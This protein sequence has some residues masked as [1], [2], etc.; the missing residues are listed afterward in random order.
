[1]ILIFSNRQEPTTDFVVD[2]LLYRE[3]DFFRINSEDILESKELIIDLDADCWVID[4]REISLNDVNAV[5]YRRWNSYGEKFNL[6]TIFKNQVVNEI[7]SELDGLSQFIFLRLR[8]TSKFL[9]DPQALKQH[10]KLYSLH[11][12]QQSGLN[13]P[14]TK[15]INNKK[16]LLSEKADSYITK[17][18]TDSFAFIDENYDEENIYKSFTES[19]TKDEIDNLE[20]SFFPSMI[21]SKINAEFEIRTFFLENEFFSTAILNSLTLDIKRSVGFYADS[22]KMVPYKLPKSIERKLKNTMKKLNLNCGAIDLIKDINGEF[23]FLEV[24]PV[25]QFLGYSNACNY[26]LEEK[27]ANWLINNDNGKI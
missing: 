15:I 6:K 1:M 11:V 22:V 16:L 24:N 18:I 2:H 27:I 7:Y 17:P 9:T 25:G 12:A 20:D 14:S 8:Q 4:G 26:R 10:N 19:I 23:Y 13:I 3:A 5:W 21:Q